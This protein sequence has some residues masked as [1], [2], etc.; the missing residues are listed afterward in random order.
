MFVLVAEEEVGVDVSGLGLVGGVTLEVVTGVVVA[1][2]EVGVSVVLEG[3]DVAV[4][5]DIGDVVADADCVLVDT[6]GVVATGG[7]VVDML[8]VVA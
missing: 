2:G 3:V 1:F 7:V 6:F 8:G 5:V 4:V